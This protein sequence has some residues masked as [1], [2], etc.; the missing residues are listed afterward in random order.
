MLQPGRHSC[1]DP[2]RCDPLNCQCQLS[3]T[4]SR[5]QK[6]GEQVFMLARSAIIIPPNQITFSPRETKGFR[7]TKHKSRKI[8]GSKHVA[9]LVRRRCGN[10]PTPTQQSRTKENYLFPG[11][12]R[13]T[14]RSD[15]G[16]IST[17]VSEV[18]L[19]YLHPLRST[20]E[21]S[22]LLSMLLQRMVCQVLVFTHSS[23][24]L[25]S[26][27]RWVRL[28]TRTRTHY[29]V[30]PLEIRSSFTAEGAAARW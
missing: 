8:I 15:M 25:V 21:S 7:C 23:H 16:Q 17:S 28:T 4:R 5:L 22:W 10:S 19:E 12:D 20:H 3:N 18:A 6:E 24:D 27:R 1:R 14:I 9:G 29:P 26:K 30:S 11:T 13:S 2:H